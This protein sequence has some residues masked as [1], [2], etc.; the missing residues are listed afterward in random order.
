M[1]P[2]MTFC[3]LLKKG[4]HAFSQL[5]PK[6]YFNT[7][8]GERRTQYKRLFLIGLN[9]SFGY[10]GYWAPNFLSFSACRWIALGRNSADFKITD[11]VVCVRGWGVVMWKE[12]GWNSEVYI[13]FPKAIVCL[14]KKK[15]LSAFIRKHCRIYNLKA[16]PPPM[17]E[18]K[19]RERVP[20]HLHFAAIHQSLTVHCKE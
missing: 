15:S 10:T 19:I 5:F 4:D 11:Q 1:R 20:F 12:Q 7:N 9:L 14:R 17:G 3:S 16:F 18:K 13:S 8:R 6:S 2:L